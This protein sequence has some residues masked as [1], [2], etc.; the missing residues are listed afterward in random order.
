MVN[1]LHQKTYRLGEPEFDSWLEQF[2]SQTLLTTRPNSGLL[3]PL[4][5]GTRGLTQKNSL[6]HVKISWP[7]I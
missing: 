3:V 5:L 4:P 1:E 2:F 6:L 7:P